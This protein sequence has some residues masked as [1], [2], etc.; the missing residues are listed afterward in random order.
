MT[1]WRLIWASLW[2]YRWLNLALVAGVALA[3]AIL[4]GSLAV[5]DSVRESL[6]R[7]G[8]ARISQATLAVTGGERFFPEDLAQRLG[9]ATGA[10]TEG[11]RSAVLSNDDA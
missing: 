9:A 7:H 5:G 8:M 6:R 10:A 11:A 1:R 2:H 4:S 3:S